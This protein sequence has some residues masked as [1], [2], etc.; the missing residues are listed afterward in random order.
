V[1]SGEPG[2]Y[3]ETL[4]RKTKRKKKERNRVLLGCQCGLLIDLPNKRTVLHFL[5][6]TGGEGDVGAG[7]EKRAN[8][9]FDINGNKSL[10]YSKKI[11]NPLLPELY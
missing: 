9:N 5:L 3:R 7:G 10:T 8:L 1:S 2:L 11:N 4:F 6:Q